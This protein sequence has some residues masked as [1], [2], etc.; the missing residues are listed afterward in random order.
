MHATY[1]LHAVRAGTQHRGSSVSESASRHNTNPSISRQTPHDFAF[2]SR[3]TQPICAYRSISLMA[4]TITTYTGCN[5]RCSRLLGRG[6]GRRCSRRLGRSR[7]RSVSQTDC[8]WYSGGCCYFIMH[9]CI[10]HAVSNPFVPS[11]VLPPHVYRAHDHVSPYL[12]LWA[13]SWA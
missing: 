12:P 4:S 3:I 1:G 2:F 13:S 5:R 9:Y 6:R 7:G 8:F 11:L 10:M